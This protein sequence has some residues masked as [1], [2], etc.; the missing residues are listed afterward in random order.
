AA[1]SVNSLGVSRSGSTVKVTRTT[2]G[3]PANSFCNWAMVALTCGQGPVQRVK[4]NEA[5]HTLP[6]RSALRTVRPLRSVSVESGAWRK[7]LSSVE[8]GGTLAQEIRGSRQAR[9]TQ[10]GKARLIRWHSG[11]R[12]LVPGED[13]VGQQHDHH[14][15]AQ[16]ERRDNHEIELGPV[17]LQ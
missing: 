3:C 5:I 13:D 10:A 14:H 6:S 8:L 4:T 16:D 15:G 7:T 11:R 12:F 9:T 1:Y 17:P 2:S